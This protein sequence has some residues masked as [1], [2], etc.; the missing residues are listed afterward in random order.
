ML[1]LRLKKT[2]CFIRS[3]NQTP[4]FLRPL[5][6]STIVTRKLFI[7]PPL[8]L[9]CGNWPNAGFTIEENRLLYPIQQPNSEFLASSRL[10]YDSYQKTFYFLSI[11]PTMR[12]LAECWIY[13]W[14]KP[15]AL[16]D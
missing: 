15:S 14:R 2:V 9:Q 3:S 8:G 10:E 4:N 13:D 11:G 16:L 5:G 7:F 1:D 12:E 6:W